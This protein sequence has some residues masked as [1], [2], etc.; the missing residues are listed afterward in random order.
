MQ[1]VKE[2]TTVPV[3]GATFSITAEGEDETKLGTTNNSG[4]F[5]IQ[6]LFS[7]FNVAVSYFLT[8]FLPRVFLHM[9]FQSYLPDAI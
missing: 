3:Q 7:F 2:D 5:T 1:K 6:N 8:T 4:T 9:P